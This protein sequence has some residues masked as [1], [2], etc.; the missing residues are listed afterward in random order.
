METI[1]LAKDTGVKTIISHLRPLVGFENYFSDSLEL[2]E[3]EAL[4]LNLHFDSYPSDTSLIPIYTLLPDWAKNGSLEI[5][6]QNISTH[7][8]EERILEELPPFK[9]NDIIVAYAPSAS[10]LVGKT[11]GEISDNQENDLGRTLLRIMSASKM[12]AVVL[13]KNINIDLAIQ[14][15]LNTQALVASNGPGLIES[16]LRFTHDRISN[17]FPK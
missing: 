11:L 1:K 10:Y 4:N 6:L 3:K 14:S 7:Y 12:N 17:T 9:G 13:Y 15:L 16:A 8:L 2:L 5:M